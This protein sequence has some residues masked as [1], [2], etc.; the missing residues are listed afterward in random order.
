MWLL[1]TLASTALAWV[2]VSAVGGEV[3]DTPPGVL[4]P[5]AVAEAARAATTTTASTA[6]TTAPPAPTVTTRA[7]TPATTAAPPPPTRTQV[8]TTRGGSA[9]V[10]CTGDAAS[11]EWATPAPG[12]EGEV[13][14]AGP[15]RVE[16][17]FEGDDDESRLTV[18]CRGGTPSARQED[19]GSGP[20]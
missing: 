13:H 7:P 16:V 10:R 8:F 17:R 9:N 11:L 2:A 14:D 4:S 5:T 19:G 20:G 12:Y 18:E 3:T 15:D 6:P 1:G